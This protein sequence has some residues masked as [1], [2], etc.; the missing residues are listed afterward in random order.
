MQNG[1]LGVA[2]GMPDFIEKR[3]GRWWVPNPV[4][5]DE[6]FAD[7]WN[8]KPRASGEVLSWTEKVYEDFYGILRRGD[9]REAAELLGPVMGRSA[10]IKAASRMGVRLAESVPIIA[11]ASEHVPQ[12]AEIGHWSRPPNGPCFSNT[13]PRYGSGLRPSKEKAKVA[14][15]SR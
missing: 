6:K 13:M 8:E 10:M 15:G 14:V 7:K 9:I 4:D 12:L 11:A 5:P 2:K 3:N 1:L